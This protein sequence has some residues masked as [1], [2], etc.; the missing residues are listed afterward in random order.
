MVT[1]VAP[2]P[3]SRTAGIAIADSALERLHEL[4]ENRPGDSLRIAVKGGGCSGLSYK[5]EWAQTPRERDK[6]FERD[7]VKIFV[8]SK[9]F[10]YLMGTELIYED[11]MASSGFRL[12]NPNEKTSCGC[13][14]SFTV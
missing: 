4:L 7:G 10:L 1:E 12:R 3:Q 6:I 8:D 5:L 9:S 11:T 13:G 2:A 14:M